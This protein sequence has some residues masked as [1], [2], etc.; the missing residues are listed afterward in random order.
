MV[1]FIC[2]EGV[3]AV[4]GHGFGLGMFEC[5][6]TAFLI[7]AYPSSQVGSGN[8]V[9][10]C[11]TLLAA[12][13]QV[14]S[15]AWYLKCNVYLLIKKLHLVSWRGCPTF[16]VQFNPNLDFQTTFFLHQ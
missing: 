3:F 1:G 16:G 6:D 5:A 4:L 12:Y 2:D 13:M 15:T 11:G 7:G 9:V 8:A 10:V 14:V